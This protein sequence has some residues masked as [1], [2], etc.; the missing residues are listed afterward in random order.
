M[1]VLIY[2]DSP[3]MNSRKANRSQAGSGFNEGEFQPVI[4]SLAVLPFTN[5]SSNPDLDFFLTGLQETTITELA[6][7]DS[8]K[9]VSRPETLPYAGIERPLD[10]IANELGVQALLLGTIQE[11]GN[12]IRVSVQLLDRYSDR[13]L[14]AE[15][16][17]REYI[18]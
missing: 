18:P 6:K 7:A 3:Q 4:Q 2:R 16:F 8:L 13:H 17:D 12:W 1:A 9:V 5:L 14:W 10:D 15:S 11:A